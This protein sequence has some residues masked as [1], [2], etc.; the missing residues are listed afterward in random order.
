MAISFQNDTS[1]LSHHRFLEDGQDI[2]RAL[3]PGKLIAYLEAKLGVSEF[4]Y[5]GSNQNSTEKVGLEI[6]LWPRIPEVLDMGLWPGQ[7]A[8]L[9]DVLRGFPQIPSI[10]CWDNVGPYRV[11]IIYYLLRGRN[12][13]SGRVKNFLHVVKTG[14]GVHPTSYPM[15]TAGS[16][17]GG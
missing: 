8:I 5:A 13:S 3:D 7:P 9:T 1:N 6:R 15:G 10:Q 16:F 4:H 17:P 14:S 11:L 12:S 2:P